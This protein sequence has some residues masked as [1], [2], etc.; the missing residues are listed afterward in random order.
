M[1]LRE[2]RS[3]PAHVEDHHDRRLCR[4]SGCAD[5]LMD[6]LTAQGPQPCE[7][8]TIHAARGLVPEV[9]SEIRG[10]SLIGVPRRGERRERLMWLGIHPSSHAD[11]I[12]GGTPGAVADL[13]PGRCRPSTMSCDC[14]DLLATS[15]LSR[16]GSSRKVGTIARSAQSVRSGRVFASSAGGDLCGSV[17]RGRSRGVPPRTE[18]VG[19][20]L[21]AVPHPSVTLPRMLEPP[22]R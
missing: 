8:G 9:Q 6:S 1:T 10:K 2:R 5:L 22:R 19:L 21:T 16:G 13:T 4:P 12:R 11:D 3:A 20:G 17:D 18:R 15:P 7:V 14:A